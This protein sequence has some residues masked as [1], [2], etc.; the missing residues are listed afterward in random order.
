LGC[1]QGNL[2]LRLA[3]LGYQVT[4]VEQDP[5]ALS[6][7]R[8]KQQSGALEL[9]P[10]NLMNVDLPTNH[11]EVVILAEVI[12]HS[13]WPE[14]MLLRALELVRPGGY[15]IVTT[16]NGAR[17]SVPL[18]TWTELQTQPKREE[19]EKRQFGDDHLWKLLPEET[20]MLLPEKIVELQSVE[21]CGSTVLINRLTEP[22]LGWF[23]LAWIERAIDVLRGV[24]LVNRWTF[25]TLC[26]AFRKRA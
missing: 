7:I 11:F 26:A 13:A 19:I 9:K 14:K 15:L 2:S 3:E 6:Y 24:P 12:E 10:G 23:P 18:Q 21:Y 5:A 8:L 22:V 17:V 16:P 20:K 1:A 4:A 25:N